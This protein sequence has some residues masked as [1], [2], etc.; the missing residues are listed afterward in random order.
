MNDDNFLTHEKSIMLF[1]R[2]FHKY[3]LNLYIF[4]FKNQRLCPMIGGYQTY[5]RIYTPWHAIYINVSSCFQES[6][7]SEGVFESKRIYENGM[8]GN[9][10][11]KGNI[12]I[13][14]QTYNDQ[15][16]NTELRHVCRFYYLYIWELVFI[17][18]LF[19][20]LTCK[21]ST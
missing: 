5:Y 14:I 1:L 6:L 4:E 11:N 17:Y 10:Y 16:S 19:P 9:Y 15:V 2:N 3:L 21:R 7:T 20:Y 18:F 13:C 12:G 8:Q